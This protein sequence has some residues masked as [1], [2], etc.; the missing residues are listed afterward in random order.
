[1]SKTITDEDIIRVGFFLIDSLA[2]L[3]DGEVLPSVRG[4]VNHRA[5]GGTAEKVVNVLDVAQGYR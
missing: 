4:E 5:G 2:N 3:I 1:M